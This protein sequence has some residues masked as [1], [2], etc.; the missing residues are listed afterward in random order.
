[1][2]L[3]CVGEGIVFFIGLFE[4]YKFVLE[5]FDFIFKLVF[6]KGLDVGM[7]FEILFIDIVDIDIGRNIGVV[8]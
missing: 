3:V 1:M 5:N 2:I 6:C 7:V 8:L 4:N